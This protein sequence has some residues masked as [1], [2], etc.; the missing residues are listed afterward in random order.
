M[1]KDCNVQGP[2]VCSTQY[3]SECWTKNEEHDV[4]KLSDNLIFQIREYVCMET[5]FIM[6]MLHMH[7]QK[8]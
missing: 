3:E 8:E 6:C 4:S 1:E 5:D 2:E 7:C